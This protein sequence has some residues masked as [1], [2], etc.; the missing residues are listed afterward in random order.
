MKEHGNWFLVEHLEKYFLVDKNIFSTQSRIVQRTEKEN[1][2]NQKSAVFWLT[3]LSGSG[4][5][6][7]AQLVER[8]LFENGFLTQL[9]DGDN[10]RSGLCGDLEFSLEDRKE[11]VR[12]IAEL[13]K[14]MIQCGIVCIN[15]FVSPTIA[16]REKAKKIIGESDYYEILIDT[17][18]D[19]CE[20]RD[21]KGL[22]KKARSG[23]IKN[24][25]GIDSP[26][27]KPVDPALAIQ[28]DGLTPEES[29]EQLYDF[30]RKTIEKK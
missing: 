15:T 19:V 6:T 9:I 27:E 1:F 25:T 10:V 12:R 26:Y 5:S 24:F 14:I 22:Y 28:T 8:R 11:N 7:I 23:E 21:V 13:T 16:I 18:L 4:K 2:L 17:P 30:I 3:G 29:A 20:E